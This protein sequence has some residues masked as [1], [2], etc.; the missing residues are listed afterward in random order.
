MPNRK[1]RLEKGIESIKEE[2][3]NHKQKR[4]SAISKGDEYLSKYYDKEI[5]GMEK[6]LKRKK[7]IVGK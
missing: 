5:K 7:D 4:A 1:K 3:E 2:I 6:Q